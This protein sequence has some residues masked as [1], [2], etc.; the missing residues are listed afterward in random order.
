MSDKIYDLFE[1]GSSPDIDETLRERGFMENLGAAMGYQFGPMTSRAQELFLFNQTTA[2]ENY[3][4][5]SDLEGYENFYAELSRAT[6][7]DHA[8]FIKHG[9]NDNIQRRRVLAET[10]WYYPSQL[11]A[12]AV[13][14]ANLPFYFPIVGQMGLVAKGGMT[15][16]QA[17]KAS[18]K[19]GLAAGVI[20]E[21]YRAPFDPLATKQEVLLT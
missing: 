15:V 8:K 16:A 19:G 21:S 9:I 14:L 20:A 6:S 10:S 11:I 5:K 1:R 13:D 7:A 18:A 2:D 12:G 17:A 3:D 4:F